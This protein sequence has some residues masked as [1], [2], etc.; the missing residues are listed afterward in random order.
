[1]GK[2]VRISYIE[3]IGGVAENASDQPGIRTAGFR[4]GID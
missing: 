2:S 3:E 1:M 4:E